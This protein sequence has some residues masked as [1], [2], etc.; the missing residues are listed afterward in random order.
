MQQDAKLKSLPPPPIIFTGSTFSASDY[1]ELPTFYNNTFLDTI[2]K[3]SNMKR[4]T[5]FT[6]QNISPK[7]PKIS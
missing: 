7:K 2:Y 1:Y 3:H 5:T 6:Q 4:N